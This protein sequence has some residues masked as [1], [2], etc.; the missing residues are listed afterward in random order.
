[1]T[2][3]SSAVIV[4]DAD[5]RVQMWNSRQRAV[6][7]AATRSWGSP[8]STWTSASPVEEPRRVCARW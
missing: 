5:L 2:S 8:S 4:V 3:V 7:L 6:G 1:M